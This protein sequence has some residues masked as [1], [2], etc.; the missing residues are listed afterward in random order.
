[1]RIEPESESAAEREG[2]VDQQN[3][4]LENAGLD[5]PDENAG[6]ADEDGPDVGPMADDPMKGEA[7][8]G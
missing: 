7:P 2:I 3:A 5:Q 4:A 8:S 1:M 6:R